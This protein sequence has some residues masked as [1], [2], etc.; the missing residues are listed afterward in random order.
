MKDPR[1]GQGRALEASRAGE[2][3]YRYFFEESP[4]SIWEVVWSAAK[5]WIDELR[6]SRVR[7]LLAYLHEHHEAVRTAVSKVEVVDFNKATLDIYR[8]PDR[9]AIWR[10]LQDFME[11]PI[12]MASPRP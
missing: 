3:R 10:G 8:A 12:A 7:D 4:H 5:A 1:A 11:R 9:E 6:A 2:A